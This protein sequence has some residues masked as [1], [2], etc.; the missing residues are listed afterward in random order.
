[1]KFYRQNLHF[2]IFLELFSDLK[3]HFLKKSYVDSLKT[4]WLGKPCIYAFFQEGWSVIRSV[5]GLA[6]LSAHWFVVLTNFLF[7]NVCLG[8]LISFIDFHCLRT[9]CGPLGL[10][11]MDDNFFFLI[12][13]S[14]SSLAWEKKWTFLLKTGAFD[15]KN[16]I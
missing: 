14:D 5:W 11:L 8:Q 13:D 6:G 1:M 2:K 3:Y 10:V 9:H 16:A 12:V 7:A 15:T 4:F